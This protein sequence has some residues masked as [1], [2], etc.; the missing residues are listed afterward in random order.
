MNITR[1]TFL[2][3]LAAVENICPEC[4]PGD[5]EGENMT[6]TA[7]DAANTLFDLI[8]RKGKGHRAGVL[9]VVTLLAEV[10]R[11]KDQEKYA[12]Q[13]AKR[14]WDGERIGR[15][16]RP[17]SLPWTSPATFPTIKRLPKRPFPAVRCGS[18]WNCSF[19]RNWTRTPSWPE[20]TR[21]SR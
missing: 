6:N 21:S 1:E 17:T 19:V 14:G 15:S 2:D 20:P 18:N 8:E 12:E 13:E 10:A 7:L 11:A 4:E 5:R 16:N 3:L 9:T